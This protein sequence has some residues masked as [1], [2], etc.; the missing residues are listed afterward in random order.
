MDG[1][2]RATDNAIIER[3]LGTLKQKYVYLNPSETG[4]SLFGGLRAFD[5]KYNN[6]RYQGINR[7]KL[8]DMYYLAA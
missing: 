4:L 6:R 5:D 7:K 8:V 3:W 1:K 2:G